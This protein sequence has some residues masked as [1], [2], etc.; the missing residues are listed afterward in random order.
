MKC[1]ALVVAS[2]FLI[3]CAPRSSRT[4]T[5]EVVQI[6]YTA[7]KTSTGIGPI[8][9]G[10][11]GIAVT[12]STTPDEYDVILDCPVHGRVIVA[13]QRLFNR[14]KSGQLVELEYR[15]YWYGSYHELK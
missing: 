3:G 14:V 6:S 2:T 8:V 13:S 7:S 9:G 10:E 15:D 1:L 5:L 11:G 12:T 4:E